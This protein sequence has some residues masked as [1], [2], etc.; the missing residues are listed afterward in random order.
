LTLPLLRSSSAAFTASRAAKG[1]ST[2]RRTDEELDHAIRQVVAWAVASDEVI[3]ILAA[4][5]LQKPDISILSDDF[6]A[7]VRAMPGPQR[8]G[9]LQTEV[10]TARHAAT[11]RVGQT[12][13]PVDGGAIDRAV[14]CSGCPGWAVVAS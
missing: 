5:G 4:A 10:L 9:V 13:S 1:T 14:C 7:E 11:P 2:E 8:A 6:L 12:K 3:D